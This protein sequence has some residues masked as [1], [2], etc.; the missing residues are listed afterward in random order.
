MPRKNRKRGRPIGDNRR[1]SVRSELRRQP[2][3]QKIARAVV[4]LAIAQA[5][6]EA[7]QQARTAKGATEQTQDGESRDA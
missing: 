4:A 2:D 3:I 5:E 7:E 1:F 6:A